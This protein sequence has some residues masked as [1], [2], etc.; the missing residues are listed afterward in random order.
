M[1]NTKKLLKDRGLEVEKH[2]LEE[3]NDRWGNLLKS[4]G[5]LSQVEIEEHDISLINIPGSDHIEG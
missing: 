2:L 3:V 4:K 1:E 5:N